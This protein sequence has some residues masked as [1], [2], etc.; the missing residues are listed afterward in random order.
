MGNKY[1]TG[2]NEWRILECPCP[3]M[4]C[5]E[6]D[7]KKWQHAICGGRVYLNSEGFIKC[8][9]HGSCLISDAKWGCE[10]H[11]GDFR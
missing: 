8:N 10:K 1:S 4:D 11:A 5:G 7:A 3:A 9:E 2:C 6:F